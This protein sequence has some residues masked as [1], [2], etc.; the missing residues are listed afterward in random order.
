MKK[1]F[2]EENLSKY[3]WNGLEDSVDK[4]LLY[5][6]KYVYDS[7]LGSNPVYVN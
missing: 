7:E 3:T 5:E 2:N 4:S 6:S 1:C